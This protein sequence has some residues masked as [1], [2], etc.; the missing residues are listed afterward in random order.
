MIKPCMFTKY[1]N[2][3]SKM[4]LSEGLSP[5]SKE[6]VHM[7][8]TITKKFTLDFIT[9]SSSLSYDYYVTASTGLK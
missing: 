6:I 5:Y 2:V 9:G 7:Q 1:N 3:L 8:T 4:D